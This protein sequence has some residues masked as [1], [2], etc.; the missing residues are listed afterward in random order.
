[1]KQGEFEDARK[2]LREAFEIAQKLDIGSGYRILGDIAEA[3]WMAGKL[4]AAQDCLDES[5]RM[6][7]ANGDLYTVRNPP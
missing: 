4:A 6:A 5:I 1:M 2:Y 3:N 7:Q